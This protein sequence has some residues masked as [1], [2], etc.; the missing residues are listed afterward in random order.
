MITI[1]IIGGILAVLGCLL[2][3]SLYRSRMHDMPKLLALPLVLLLGA[4]MGYHYLQVLGK[5]VE[6]KPEGK[7]I[8]VHH[9]TDGIEIELWTN[10]GGDSR[11]YT[12]PYSE[13]DRKALEE[14]RRRAANGVPVQG[15]FE[16]GEEEPGTGR[17][18]RDTLTLTIPNRNTS[19]NY[20]DNE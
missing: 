10:I 14:A 9:V 4:L 16:K 12:Y 2:C 18:P 11:L 5:P 6:G 1:Y 20:G 19:K 15:E 13:E 3:Y 7:F 17:T 8:Y